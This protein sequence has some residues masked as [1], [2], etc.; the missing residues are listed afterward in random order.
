MRFHNSLQFYRRKVGL[1]QQELADKIG[2]KRPY[3]SFMENGYRLPDVELL[4]TIASCLGCTVGQIY[5]PNIQ[6]LI[7]EYDAEN[8]KRLEDLKK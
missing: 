4:E 3:L 8:K 2:I 7:L 6:N 5:P 1:K